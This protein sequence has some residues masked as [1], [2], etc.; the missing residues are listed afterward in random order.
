MKARIYA[1]LAAHGV[2]VAAAL[3]AQA[4][5]AQQ[6]VTSAQA[7]RVA[8][9]LYR[10]PQ[11]GGDQ[12]LDLNWLGGYALVSEE[13]EVDLPKGAAVLRFEGVAAGM[14]PE[15]AIISG[16]PAGVGEKN[17]DAELLS[18]RNLYAR[19]FGRPVLLRR[20][21]PRGHVREEPA[22]IRSA[23]DGAAVVQTKAGFE[24]AGCGGLNDALVWPEAPQDLQARPTLSVATQSARAQRVKVRLSYLAWG[25]DWQAHYVARLAPGAQSAEMT[26]WVTLASSDDTS[27][28]Q[29]ETA[30]VGGRPNF[31]EVREGPDGSGEL[32]LHCQ[33]SA[34]PAPPPPV[35]ETMPVPA[36]MM[37]MRADIVVTA[38]RAKAMEVQ[39]E[40][41][42]DLKL[43]RVPV[44]T[45]VAAH[46]MKQVALFDA[47]PV[48]VALVHGAEINP[49]ADTAE[50]TVRVKL[51][52][53]NS[54]ADGLGMALPAGRLAVV[55][56]VGEAAL[57]VGEGPLPDKAEG[58]EVN[59]DIAASPQV[60]VVQ[61]RVAQGKNRYRLTV[62]VTN[63]NRWPVRFEGRLLLGAGERLQAPSTPLAR[64]DGA[65]LWVVSVPAGGRSSLSVGIIR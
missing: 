45:T 52:W 46:A 5:C 34:P 54:K 19:S 33:L 6:V 32:V 63:A 60:H 24:L 18:P 15:S 39:Q 14:L 30:V 3:A 64:R 57:P 43:Y 4:G 28:A 48:K 51:R 2:A 38:M 55:E 47:R 8:V 65:P 13:R 29:A 22:I 9:T 12:P 23:P 59:V 41:L 61:R 17:L 44:P 20:A 16:L 26:A 42:G 10:A 7:G 58:E 40:A 36:P 35:I 56:K 11:R 1:R 49:D 53:R 37:A 21:D 50:P 62:E 25:F 27:F 31:H